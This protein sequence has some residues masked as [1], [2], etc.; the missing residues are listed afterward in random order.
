MEDYNQAIQRDPELSEAYRGRGRSYYDLGR[1]PEAIEDY[2]QAIK[3]DQELKKK[4]TDR[5]DVNEVGRL[6]PKLAGAY[7]DRANA[8]REMGQYEQA[9]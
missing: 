2:Y 8:C 7:Y 3:I 4:A 5:G 9:L 1:R 6:D